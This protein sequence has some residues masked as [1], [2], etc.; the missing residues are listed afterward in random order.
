MNKDIAFCII[1]HLD[2]LDDINSFKL[3]NKAFYKAYKMFFLMINTESEYII[4]EDESFY[5]TII[6]DHKFYCFKEALI[7]YLYG[8]EF[9]DYIDLLKRIKFKNLNIVKKI[10]PIKITNNRESF[11][12]LYYG[13]EK[14][15]NR[16]RYNIDLVEICDG[17]EYCTYN[18]VNVP[19]NC[20]VEDIDHL[21]I[22][23]KCQNYRLKYDTFHSTK[24][25]NITDRKYEPIIDNNF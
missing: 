4:R 6:H 7:E 14:V 17:C 23:T 16:L 8:L 5:I 20:Y 2:S 25:I 21:N 10:H 9:Y 22:Y 19:T 24:S 18:T 12:Y 3:V 1:K 13:L 15:S 11:I